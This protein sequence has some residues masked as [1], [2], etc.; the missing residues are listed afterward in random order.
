MAV[1][2]M[3][4]VTVT[5]TVTVVMIT[6]IAVVCF[7]QP[8]LVTHLLFVRLLLKPGGHLSSI[9]QPPRSRQLL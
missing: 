4:T 5:V 2:I 7:Q 6:A 9:P 1:E 3:I 8:P